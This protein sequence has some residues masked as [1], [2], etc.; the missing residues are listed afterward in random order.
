MPQRASMTSALRSRR[1][2]SS[3]AALKKAD[4]AAKEA[5]AVGDTPY[6][7]ISA[8]QA[9]MGT[10]ALLSGGFPGDELKRAGAD[11]IYDDVFHLLTNY[12]GSP[13]SR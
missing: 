3:P 6:D 5:V 12:D 9:G 13:L 2:T 4:V 8:G 10:V 7:V 11:M 1:Q